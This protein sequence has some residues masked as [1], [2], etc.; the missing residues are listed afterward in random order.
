MTRQHS[1]LSGNHGS[2]AV[3][4]ALVLV[5][6]IGIMAFAMDVGYLYFQDN[7]CQQAVEAAALSGVRHICEGDWEQVSR[8]IAAEH[9]LADD[10][11]NLLVETGFYDTRDTFS[12]DLGDFKDFGQPPPGRYLNAVHV[13]LNQTVE[14]LSGMNRPVTVIAEA[15]AYLQR[16]DIASLDPMGTIRLGHNSTWKHTV[17]F[18]NGQIQYPQHASA[19]GR[20]YQPPEFI[21]CE[22]LAAG[23]IFGCP[24]TV[25]PFGWTGEEVM[26]IEWDSGSPQSFASAKT[27]IDPI[28]E[29]RP[30]DDITLDYWR[31]RAD[32]VYTPDQ[33]GQDNVYYGQ[34]NDFQGKLTYFVDPSGRQGNGHRVIFFD[35]G[36]NTPGTVLIG[37]AAHSPDIINHIPNGNTIADL[38]F[39]ATCPVRVQN[40]MPIGFSLH[41]GGEDDDQVVIISAGNIEIYFRDVSFEGAVFR[42]GKDFIKFEVSGPERLHRIRVIADGSIYGKF[43]GGYTNDPGLSELRNNSRFGS[44]CPPGMARLGHLEPS[45]N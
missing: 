40:L 38:T 34:G 31:N 7:R 30:V 27:G 22:L 24:V 17:F 13:R 6:L 11:N 5:L 29:I 41:V 3:S 2:V 42:T 19:S 1:T 36:Q 32:K 21:D 26:E 28:T 12:E 9:G 43:Y 37:P 14:S 8:R 16:I 33:A 15:V 18:S 39:V 25:R 45:S 44:P 23:R 10:D 20:L 35:A 4:V